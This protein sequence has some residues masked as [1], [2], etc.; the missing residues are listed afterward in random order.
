[1]VLSMSA[2]MSE[3]I[4]LFWLTMEDRIKQSEY[5]GLVRDVRGEQWL[6]PDRWYLSFMRLSCLCC[7]PFVILSGYPSSLYCI[8]VHCL[9]EACSIHSADPQVSIKLIPTAISLSF[10]QQSNSNQKQDNKHTNHNPNPPTD[11]VQN[12]QPHHHSLLLWP[13]C[14]LLRC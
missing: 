7:L 9:T 3:T 10:I 2:C 6:S 13:P 12:V 1:M 14:S 8:Q 5:V 11:H 4:G